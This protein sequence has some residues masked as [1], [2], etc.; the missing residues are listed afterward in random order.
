MCKRFVRTSLSSCEDVRTRPLEVQQQQ[1]AGTTNTNASAAAGKKNPDKIPKE[2]PCVLVTASSDGT[3]RLF[4]IPEER[5]WS[6]PIEASA[7]LYHPSYVYTARSFMAPPGGAGG[8]PGAPPGGGGG[9]LKELYVVSGGHGFGLKVWRCERQGEQG[10][11]VGAHG[12]FEQVMGRSSQHG[13][14]RD[15]LRISRMSSLTF[16]H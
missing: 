15:V 6:T 8:A 14:P 13:V 2:F 12:V 1:P 10:E 9:V 3:V 16:V 11:V 7:V 4:P 5:N